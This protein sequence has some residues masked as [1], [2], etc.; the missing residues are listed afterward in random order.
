MKKLIFSSILFL[1]AAQSFAEPT[2]GMTPRTLTMRDFLFRTHVMYSSGKYLDSSA[3][4]IWSLSEISY[5]FDDC[6]LIRV[7]VPVLMQNFGENMNSVGLGDVILDCKYNFYNPTKEL[8]YTS[9][10]T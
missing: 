10:T 9:S 8:S 4:S 1:A 3:T 6:F 7:A 2:V 5:G